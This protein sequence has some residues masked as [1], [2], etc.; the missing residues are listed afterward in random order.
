MGAII[1]VH[2]WAIQT[3]EMESDNNH[4]PVRNSHRSGAVPHRYK[5]GQDAFVGDCRP[6]SGLVGLQNAVCP[7]ILLRGRIVMVAYPDYR[8]VN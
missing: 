3:L 1:H 8:F 4:I 2:C 7:Q 6:V 5:F